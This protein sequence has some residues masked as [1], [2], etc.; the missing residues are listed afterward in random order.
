MRCQAQPSRSLKLLRSYR[1]R[2]NDIVRIKLVADRIVVAS[3][4]ATSGL[5]GRV[6]LVI[7]SCSRSGGG[8]RDCPFTLVRN[9]FGIQAIPFGLCCCVTLRLLICLVPFNVCLISSHV[10]VRSHASL[11]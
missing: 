10:T 4:G 5:R 2:P 6:S 9:K 1:F 3:N 8:S 11:K 7:Y